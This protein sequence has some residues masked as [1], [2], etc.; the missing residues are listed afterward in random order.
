VTVHH[1]VVVANTVLMYKMRKLRS[2]FIR[3]YAW[4]SFDAILSVRSCV[5]SCG[6]VLGTP[7]N[8]AK[9]KLQRLP[10]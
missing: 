10:W 1:S 6:Q 2:H 8:D 5:Q 7:L 9:L 4:R 3:G